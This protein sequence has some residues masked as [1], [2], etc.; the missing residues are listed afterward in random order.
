[1][2][3]KCEAPG[4]PTG[5]LRDALRRENLSTEPWNMRADG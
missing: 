5:R 3:A 4:L 2:A 1:M